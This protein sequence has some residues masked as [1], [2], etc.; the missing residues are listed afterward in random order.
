MMMEAARASETSINIQLRTRQYIPED[1]ELN[2]MF[3]VERLLAPRPTPKLEGHPL[4][5]VRDY[6]FN[7]FAG[8]PSIS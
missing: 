4:S 1:T 2:I 8:N 7:I 6:L 5:A 3:H